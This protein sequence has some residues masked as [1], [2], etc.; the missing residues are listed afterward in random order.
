MSKGTNICHLSVFVP[1]VYI[2]ALQIKAHH[3]RRV[4]VLAGIMIVG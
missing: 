4:C 3:F 2:R 1:V